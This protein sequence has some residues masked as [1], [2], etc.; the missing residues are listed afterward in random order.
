MLFSVLFQPL[1]VTQIKK[2][3]SLI[4]EAANR[5]KVEIKE[6]EEERYKHLV[7]IGNVL[8]PSVPISNDE[9]C[10]KYVLVIC[11]YTIM[12]VYVCPCASNRV[13]GERER[14]VVWGGGGLF[15]VHTRAYSVCIGEVHV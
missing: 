8:H 9:V 15:K 14:E 2:V 7:M 11:T 4:E 1:T 12:C 3:Q 13:G 6:C 5:T 10:N